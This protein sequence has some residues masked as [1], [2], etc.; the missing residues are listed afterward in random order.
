MIESNGPHIL[1]YLPLSDDFQSLW[2][3]GGLGKGKTFVSIYLAEN[4]SRLA[5]Q[6]KYEDETNPIKILEFYCASTD[7][8]RNTSVAIL[9]RLIYR[10][11]R[12]NSGLGKHLIPDFE[13]LGQELFRT[14]TD[15][16]S[17]LWLYLQNMVK[18][19]AASME[20]LVS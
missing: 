17:A 2:I 5:T 12:M 11:F 15:A 8:S 16:S 6:A 3:C 20:F 19:Q 18:E 13:V 10:L 7:S 1:F 14:S 9:R 4:I